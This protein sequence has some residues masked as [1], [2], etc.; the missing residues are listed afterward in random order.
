[1]DKIIIFETRKILTRAIEHHKEIIKAPKEVYANIDLF[2]EWGG[3]LISILY[4]RGPNDSISLNHKL[5]GM[6]FVESNWQNLESYS[7]K[8]YFA[9]AI[10]RL[11]DFAEIPSIP[12][13]DD[14]RFNHGI[15]LMNRSKICMPDYVNKSIERIKN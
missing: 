11:C 14:Y 3:F 5:M 9:G 1:M 4:D 8:P 7:K 13:I 15:E 12:T 6:N 2:P 10:K